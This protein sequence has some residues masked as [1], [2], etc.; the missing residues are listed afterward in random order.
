MFINITLKIIPKQMNK[1][2]P[3]FSAQQFTYHYL[4]ILQ[5]Q[6]A[7]KKLVTCKMLQSMSR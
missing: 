2:A 4:K 6:D 1:L 7:H 5:L 3:A